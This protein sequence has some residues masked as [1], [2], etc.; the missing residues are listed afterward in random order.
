MIR[1]W[2]NAKSRRVYESG[3]NRGFTGLDGEQ[4]LEALKLLHASSNL[5][6]L[7]MFR[8]YRLHKLTGDRQG[9]WSLTVNGPWRICF[10]FRGGNAFDVEITDYH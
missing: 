10:R 4:A 5:Q 8:S 9:Q 1:T 2:K 3:S 7:G 6:A